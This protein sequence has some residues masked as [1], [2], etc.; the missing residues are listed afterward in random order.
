M[1]VQK[2]LTEIEGTIEN[3]IALIEIEEITSIGTAEIITTI[4]IEETTLRE[5]EG[6]FMIVTDEMV[7][8]GGMVTTEREVHI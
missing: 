1:T 8:I 6:T 2:D 5:T 3:E 7:S 4:E